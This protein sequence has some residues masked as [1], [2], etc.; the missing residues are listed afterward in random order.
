[1]ISK[2][3]QYMIYSTLAFTI[4]NAIAKHLN[5]Y[6][7]FQL[8]FFRSLFTV[9]FCTIYLKH[10]SI[11][12]LGNERKLLIARGV[13]GVLSMVSFFYALQLMPFGS[14]V[15]LRYLAPVFATMMGLWFLKEKV[16]SIQWLFFLMAFGGAVLLKGFDGRISLFALCL[17]LCSAA[18]VG[19]VYV[20]I[21]K[22]GMKDHPLVIINY[23]MSIGVLIGG[24]FTVLYGKM[25]IGTDWWWFL[26]MGIAGFFGQLFVTQAFQ[27]AEANKI[28]PIS[29]LEVV[30]S[31]LLGF[32]FF[33]ETH[34]YWS[35]LGI[36][37]IIGGMLLNLVVKG[38]E[39]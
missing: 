22:I 30:F 19:V 13:I 33:G 36:L 4:L 23:F 15:S 8:V 12:I 29:Y 7:P 5:G 1:M 6:H 21:R 10:Q 9:V 17:I 35:L 25:P 39:R 18:L 38:R 24:V 27:M 20:L 32:F 11:S 26:G 37:L 2:P 31:L 34:S 14:A 3:V 16:K 28:A